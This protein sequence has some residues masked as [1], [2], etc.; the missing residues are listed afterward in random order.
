VRTRIGDADRLADE[1]LQRLQGR[2]AE[3]RR[4][5]LREDDVRAAGGLETLQRDVL[6]VEEAEADE[7][8]L[9]HGGP[10]IPPPVMNVEGAGRKR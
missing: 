9:P 4:V 7:D 8:E 1:E 2:P 3:A 6:L 10:A 5:E